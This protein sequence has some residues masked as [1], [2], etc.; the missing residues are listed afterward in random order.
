MTVIIVEIEH[1]MATLDPGQQGEKDTNLWDMAP[2][3]DI[4]SKDCPVKSVP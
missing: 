2:P 3:K 1:N 4:L